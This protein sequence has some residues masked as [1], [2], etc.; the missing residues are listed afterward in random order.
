MKKSLYVI[1]IGFL[2]LAGGAY[3]QVAS[4]STNSVSCPQ[5]GYNGDH[6]GDGLPNFKDEDFLKTFKPAWAN[7][8]SGSISAT[9]GQTIGDGTHP[10]PRDGT[11]F[12][13]RKNGRGRVY[14]TKQNA[15]GT[16]LCLG[17]GQGKQRRRGQ[18]RG[19]GLCKRDGSCRNVLPVVETTGN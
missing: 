6:D 5:N 18:G 14:G 9:A 16:S 15:S 19:N 8:P 1:M 4:G 12:G 7:R 17:K 2:C 3:A 13:A 11:G 10:A